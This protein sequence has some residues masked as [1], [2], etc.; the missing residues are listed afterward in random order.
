MYLVLTGAVSVFQL[1]V[2]RWLHLDR[3]ASKH[4]SLASGG[5]A[6]ISMA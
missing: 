4:R 1:W 3:T 5:A 6:P 2:E